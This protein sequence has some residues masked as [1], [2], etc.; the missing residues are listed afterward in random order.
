M[1]SF[2]YL[3]VLGPDPTVTANLSITMVEADLIEE[4]P[5]FDDPP[6][7]EDK[8]PDEGEC[9]NEEMRVAIWPCITVPLQSSLATFCASVRR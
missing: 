1:F 9:I 8:I 7:F 6:G 5:N 3:Q 2:R 4:E